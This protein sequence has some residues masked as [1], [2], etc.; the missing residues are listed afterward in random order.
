M[1]TAGTQPVAEPLYYLPREVAAMLRCSEW[2]VKEQARKRRIP[3]IWIGGS[4][5]FTA[6]HIREMVALFERRP[7]GESTA[8]AADQARA[9]R[10]VDAHGQVVRLTARRPRR[11]RKAAG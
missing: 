11:A 10:P 6:D 5:R 7:A 9:H 3:F 2:W 1:T 4:Y 8:P